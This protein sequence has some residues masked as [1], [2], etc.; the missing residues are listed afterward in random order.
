M[1][2]TL[3]ALLLSSALILMISGCS[4]A[5]TQALSPMQFSTDSMQRYSSFTIATNDVNDTIPEDKRELFEN[6]LRELLTK[7]G[8]TD[9]GSLKIEY[10]F[11]AYDEGNRVARYL[12]GFGAGKAEI[13]VKASYYDTNT[14]KLLVE[15]STKGELVMG[16]LGGSFDGTL[17]RAAEDIH[18]FTKENFMTKS[19]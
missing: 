8:Y 17:I 3:K 12:I 18:K 13:V 6:K 4:T 2:N 15:T 16:V 19:Q 1:K 9:N 7:D 11:E 10:S 14:N 5:K